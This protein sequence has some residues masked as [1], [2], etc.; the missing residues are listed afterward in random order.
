MDVKRIQEAYLSNNN[1]YKM[2]L[3]S[4][5]TVYTPANGYRRQIHDF[6]H[7]AT[8][9]NFVVLLVPHTS[10]TSHT[11]ITLANISRIIIDI[12]QAK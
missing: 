8:H 7:I 10:S 2:N 3:S 4:I 1:E 6:K 9:S 5:G 12:I 11:E